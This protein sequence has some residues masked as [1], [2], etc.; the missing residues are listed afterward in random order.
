MKNAANI[1]VGSV[2]WKTV[3]LV[4]GKSFGRNNVCCFRDTMN[5][6]PYAETIDNNINSCIA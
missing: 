3:S 4:I 1:N 6:M 2:S 5:G